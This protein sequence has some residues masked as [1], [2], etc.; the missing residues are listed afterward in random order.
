MEE[1]RKQWIGI[2]KV[3]KENLSTFFSRG[4]M[5]PD[6]NMKVHKGLYKVHKEYCKA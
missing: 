4:K 2:F 3:L 6:K 1:I 5:I